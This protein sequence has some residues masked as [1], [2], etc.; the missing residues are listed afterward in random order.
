MK[1]GLTMK[2]M[3]DL[4]GVH[5]SQ[6]HK[7]EKGLLTPRVVWQRKIAEVTNGEVTPAQLATFAA[8][9]AE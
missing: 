9:A 3:A 5:K 7:W 4:L 1:N 2:A 6:I 8:E